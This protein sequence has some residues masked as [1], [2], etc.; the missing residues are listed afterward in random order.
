MFE[1]DS[2]SRKPRE[3]KSLTGA[4]KQLIQLKN[5]GTQVHINDNLD[6]FSMTGIELKCDAQLA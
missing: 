3:S 6:I 2:C 4:L 5:M 1:I